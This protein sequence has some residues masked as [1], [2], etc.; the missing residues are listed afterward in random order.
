MCVEG[1]ALPA[2]TRRGSRLP[3][4]HS[5]GKKVENKC[6]CLLDLVSLKEERRGLAGCVCSESHLLPS[7]RWSCRCLA[8]PRLQCG[9]W[10]RVSPVHRHGAVSFELG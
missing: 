2:R 9:L 4:E 1:C 5:D 7:S 6:F 8:A 10:G 3:S